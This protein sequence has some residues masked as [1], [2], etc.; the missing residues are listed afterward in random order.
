VP[1]TPIHGDECVAFPV[2]LKFTRF[3]IGI[4]ANTLSSKYVCNPKTASQIYKLFSRVAVLSAK[5]F[6]FAVDK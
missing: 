5:I 2:L 1:F 6:N 4:K 3:L